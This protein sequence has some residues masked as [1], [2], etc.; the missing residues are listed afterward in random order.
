[1]HIALEASAFLLGSAQNFYGLFSLGRAAAERSCT[2]LTPVAFWWGCC[3][4]KTSWGKGAQN[5]DVCTKDEFHGSSDRL[6]WKHFCHFI[7]F[8]HSS[9]EIDPGRNFHEFPFCT[10]L[11]Q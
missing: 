7:A 9:I 6:E 10:T 5:G 8:C 11:Y 3:T 4:R 1:M 2:R